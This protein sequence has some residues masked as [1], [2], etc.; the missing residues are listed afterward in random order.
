M[1]SFNRRTFAT[2]PRR[3]GFQSTLFDLQ[4]R[5]RTIN[6]DVPAH[7]PDYSLNRQTTVGKRLENFAQAAGHT[8]AASVNRGIDSKKITNETPTIPIVRTVTDV[9]TPGSSARLIGLQNPNNR[10]TALG[11][12]QLQRHSSDNLVSQ[13]QHNIEPL[14]TPSTNHASLSHH[15]RQHSQQFD[16]NRYHFRK[17]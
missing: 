3:Q 5:K 10:R 12:R 13:T 11:L 16:Q 9:T 6:R 7:F 4:G 2:Q 8:S 17:K 1:A 15:S 14:S